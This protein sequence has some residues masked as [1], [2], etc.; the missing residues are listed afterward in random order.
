MG[1]LISP[2]PI[3]SPNWSN[4]SLKPGFSPTFNV[5]LRYIANASNDIELNWTHLNTS[6]NDSFAASPTQMVGPPYLIGPN[7]S[8]YSLGSGGVK[9]DYDAVNVDGGHTFCT[10]CPFQLRVFGGLQFARIGQDVNGLFQSTDGTDSS[11]YTNHSLFTGVGPRLGVK[12]QYVFGDFQLIGEAAASGLIGTS[13]SHLDFT[14]NTPAVGPNA[15]ALF[16]PNSTQVVPGIDA[17][18]ATAYTFPSTSYGQFKLEL[19][20]QAAIYFNVI[21]EYSLTQI[22]TT[23]PVTGVFLA[24]EQH[25]Q[26]NFTTQGPYLTGSWAF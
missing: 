21:N 8:P 6:T 16:S 23:I 24:T 17:R 5:G 14:T 13:K 11:G 7:S 3:T 4:Q 19:G 1:T 9:F 12:G 22:S 26:S 25:S 15:Q 18:L 20:Y 2:L 10:E